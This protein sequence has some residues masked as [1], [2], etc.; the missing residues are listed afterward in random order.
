MT[1]QER[2][3]DKAVL[4]TPDG[5]VPLACYG[6]RAML[7]EDVI[8]APD[9]LALRWTATGP[10][11]MTLWLVAGVFF[12]KDGVYVGHLMCANAK[13]LHNGDSIVVDLKDVT[14]AEM[15]SP[16]Q[17]LAGWRARKA[18]ERRRAADKTEAMR[19]MA[20]RAAAGDRAFTLDVD[21][22]LDDVF[23]AKVFTNET[24]VGSTEE[25]LDVS[26]QE[27]DGTQY[28]RV[29]M[30]ETYYNHI[31]ES[32]GYGNMESISIQ[33]T[34]TG[35]VPKDFVGCDMDRVFQGSVNN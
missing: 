24:V 8:V 2:I 26:L 6:Y 9:G 27:R 25:H 33:P 15:V 21:F 16:V 1:T 5:L 12:Q 14:F 32:V 35:M 29:R 3:W 31:N 17:L 23:D 30:P 20:E 28:G 18:G 11:R 4:F 22:N 19:E 34:M 10:D 13:H 7:H